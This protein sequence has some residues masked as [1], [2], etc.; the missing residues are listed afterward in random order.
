[1]G[2][3]TE[4]ELHY[5]EIFMSVKATLPNAYCSIQDLSIS[6]KE[7]LLETLLYFNG[8]H[9]DK[10]SSISSAKS[11]FNKLPSHERFFAYNGSGTVL[12]LSTK[13]ATDKELLIDDLFENI[14]MY[15]PS[16]SIPAQGSASFIEKKA[17]KDFTA[18]FLQ[19]LEINRALL[20]QG[21]PHANEYVKDPEKGLRWITAQKTPERQRL[22]K[23]LF[24]EIRYISHAE[25]LTAIQTCVEETKKLLKPGPVIFITGRAK[26]SNYY[27]SLLFAHYWREQG[28]PIDCAV[29]NLT[30]LD[31]SSLSGNFLDIDDMSYSGSQTETMLM[32]KFRI[33]ANKLRMYLKETIGTN[34]GFKNTYFVLP[35]HII[36]DTLEKNNFN[37][38]LVRAFM[39]EASFDRLT[40][41]DITKL[42]FQVVTSERIPYMPSVSEEDKKKIEYLFNEE[43]HTSVYFNHK[44]ADMPSTYLLPIATGVVPEKMIILNQYS[45]ST[46][47]SL[48]NNIQ[49]DGAEFLPF[50]QHCSPEERQLPK[51]RNNIYSNDPMSDVYRCPYAW[52]K[53]IDYDKGTYTPPPGPV[54]SMEPPRKENT[55]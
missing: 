34:P 49:G 8:Q 48:L 2:D 6:D 18:K 47:A 39:S 53:R 27:I 13:K 35:R 30:E 3:F 52:Y 36:D 14:M 11:L 32:D 38:I 9:M 40:K 16:L 22:A 28:L 29:Q 26:K 7:S 54:V 43:V 51:N 37:Y 15:L 31:P 25:L 10:N 50:I 33:F 42:P 20:L 44:V 45:E 41:T 24:D 21:P 12:N 4:A 5:K 46:N 19:H 23:I 17:N 55:E 1:M